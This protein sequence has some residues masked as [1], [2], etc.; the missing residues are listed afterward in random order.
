MVRFVR[1][2]MECFIARTSGPATLMALFRDE[3]PTDYKATERE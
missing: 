1:V 2:F 3:K